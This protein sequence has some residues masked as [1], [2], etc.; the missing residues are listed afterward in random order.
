MTRNT[1]L[2]GAACLGGMLVAAACAPSDPDRFAGAPF[3]PY[4]GAAST[5][6]DTCLQNNRIWG[7]RVLDER[8]LLV[9]DRNNRPFLVQLSGSCI[10]LTDINT[11][12]GFETSTNLA[13]LSQG[14]RVLYRDP[15][16]GRMSCFVT[17]VQPYGPGPYAQDFRPY[18]S[19]D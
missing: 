2:L 9:N 3:V 4:A 7:W 18:S 12:I 13:C 15:T 5:N 8:T 16:L 6:N 1:V 17:D 10:G 11:R 19:I 14:D